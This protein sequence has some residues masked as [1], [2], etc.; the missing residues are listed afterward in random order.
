MESI[1]KSIITITSITIN[2]PGIHIPVHFLIPTP[3]N[4]NL[5]ET[6]CC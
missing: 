6:N 2:I 4:R 3:D 5:P 1:F